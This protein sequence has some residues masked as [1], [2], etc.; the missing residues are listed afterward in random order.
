MSTFKKAL[1]S[2]WIRIK[3]PGTVIAIASAVVI[4]LNE[5]GIAV[6][7]ESISTI[8]NNVCYILIALG[9]MNNPVSDGMYVPGIKD[10]LMD[11]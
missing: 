10:D 7:N 4:I 11:K 6:N 5:L 2:M 9:V 3:N 1:N 8:V